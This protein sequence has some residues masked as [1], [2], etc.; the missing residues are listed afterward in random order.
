MSE[1]FHTNAVA[2]DAL[3]A[4]IA[5]LPKSEPVPPSAFERGVAEELKGLAEQLLSGAAHVE[6]F[7]LTVSDENQKMEIIVR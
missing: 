4:F 6:H 1:I 3:N 7:S 2:P 5:A